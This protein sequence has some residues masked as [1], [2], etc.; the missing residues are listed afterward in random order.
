MPTAPSRAMASGPRC[1]AIL[2]VSS[3]ALSGADFSRPRAADS[4]TGRHARVM[5]TR[6]LSGRDRLLST[7]LK[8]DSRSRLRRSR[9]RP[10]CPTSP[11]SGSANV[12]CDSVVELG[13]SGVGI[14]P[15]PTGIQELQMAN[16]G[17]SKNLD[18]VSQR[19]KHSTRSRR[20]VL[21]RQAP[22]NCK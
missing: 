12:R 21:G 17:G 7:V 11:A 8:P 3:L 4:R 13:I 10:G 16:T 9:R 22:L 2:T 20:F 18:M 6:T 5:R 1:C 15:R 19:L 14:R